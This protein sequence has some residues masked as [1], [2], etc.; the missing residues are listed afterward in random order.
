MKSSII[1]KE[2]NLEIYLD[3]AATTP[4][5]FF[6]KSQ[7][8]KHLGLYQYPTPYSILC[9]NP[10]SSHKKG[11]EAK[12]IIESAKKTILKGLGASEGEIVFTSGGTE[13]NNLVILGLAN[14]LIEIGKTTIVT[15]EI[16][17]PSILESCAYLEKIGFNVIYAPI[18]TYG[19]VC[20][21]NL[22]R[23][24]KA[25]KERIGL[26]TIQTVN[27]EIGTIQNIIR[28]GKYCREYNILF[29]TDAVQ[30]I[31]HEKI[32]AD[33]CNLDFISI[34]GH[35]FHAPKGIGALYVRNPKLL[36]PIFYGGGQQIGLRSGTENV[37]GIKCLAGE[38]SHSLNLDL[39][40]NHFYNLREVFKKEL[41]TCMKVKYSFNGR[42][43]VHNII[44]LTIPGVL[45]EAL[46]MRLNEEGVYVSTKSAC[47]SNSLEPSHV[48]KAIGLPDQ[49]ALCT[50]RI[51]TSSYNTEE[52]MKIAAKK[53]AV[54]VDELYSLTNLPSDTEAE[55]AVVD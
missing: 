6:T 28:I 35:K 31:G 34:S 54:A 51:S 32:I 50:I 26:V 53:I 49:K 21:V 40:N 44:S 30:A 48:L 10:S 15:T 52:E 3:N 1:R 12:Q 36:S 8:Q 2:N 38:L 39:Q 27:S 13:S 19:E 41:K 16:E 17:H 4:I 37:I 43:G 20:M 29:H 33:S 55:M 14:H 25:N 11:K 47:H 22:E 7:L 23:L 45:G 46:A 9:G 5:G 42:A 18:N 24:I